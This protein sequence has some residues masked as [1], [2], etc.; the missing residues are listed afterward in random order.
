MLELFRENK[1]D[2]VI[3]DFF[4]DA[5][6][7]AAKTLGIPFII[8]ST[9]ELTPGIKKKKKKKKKSKPLLCGLKCTHLKV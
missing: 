3:C 1:M 8:S 9:L 2:I 4:I 6:Y 5:C 7:D